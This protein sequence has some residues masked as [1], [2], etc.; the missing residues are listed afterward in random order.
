MNQ[1][2]QTRIQVLNSVL[3]YH[4]PIAQAAEIMGMSER[5]T[6]RLLAAYR[7]D[8]AVA[9][10]HGNRGRRPHN[11]VPETAAAA[12][13][14]L[15]SNGYAGANHTHFTELLREREGIDLSRPTVRRIL[16][17]AGMGSPRSRRS[18]QHRYR[19][20]RMPQEGML[21]QI[22][23]SQHPWLED[24]GPKLTL[25]IAVDDAT[26]TVAQAVFRTTEDTRGYLVLLEGLIRQW[27]IPLALYSDRHS[28]F[29][30]NARQKPVPV[31]TTQFARVTRELGIQQIFAL[32]PQAK[33]RVERMLETFQDRLTTE[34]R[35]AGASNIDEASLVLQEFL[36]RF[37]ARFS[38]A[39]EQPE[40][41][42]RPEPDELSL[43]EV[44]CLKDTRKVA[45]DNT[46][47]YQWRVLQLLPGAERPSYAGLR[48][49]VL[50]RAD[51]ELMIRYQG[52]AVD[53]QEGPPP[54]SALWGAA[55]ACSP[56]PELHQV[57]DGVAH[58]Y[59]NGYMNGHM[60]GHMNEAQRERLAALE[61]A[62]EN[63]EEADVESV[64]SK[65]RRGKGNPPVRHQLRRAPTQAQ[66]ARWEAVQLAKEQ[67]LSVRAIAQ[68]L[69]MARD[70]VGKYA[71]AENPPTK[72]LSA[73]ERAKAEALAGL[74]TAAD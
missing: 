20:R 50:E 21:V 45:R 31:E 18:Q 1:Q 63:E 47:K 57:A 17:K 26:G 55:S 19:R 70:T 36:P 30:Y 54:S 56:G 24:R 16:V 9:L 48:V 59:M 13:V 68:R 15:A 39:A 6:K 67:R 73:K 27:G 22:D 5:H 69:G 58:G 2:E 33:G 23:G 14:K 51:G 32:S 11:A 4:L 28:A 72:K 25:L 66:Q 43:T 40:T 37:N 7:K 12:V 10:A 65:G 64:Y 61:P 60:N 44:I 38:V 71:K 42:Y 53:F 52:E 46:V 3:E 49:E 29:K 62:N 35:L 41:A 34:L 74:M 8:G